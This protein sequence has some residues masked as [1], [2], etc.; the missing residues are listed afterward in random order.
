MQSEDILYAFEIQSHIVTRGGTQTRSSVFRTA[1]SIQPWE[2]SI[3]R[4]PWTRAS[5]RTGTLADLPF[6]CFSRSRRFDGRGLFE[7]RR[8]NLIRMN[9]PALNLAPRRLRGSF[10]FPF[11]AFFLSVCF[12]LTIQN[13][14]LLKC[15]SFDECFPRMNRYYIIL[16]GFR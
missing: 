12:S 4:L 1:L 11:S 7:G 3:S 9:P 13:K 14:I 16:L 15:E 8:S 10:V 5:R 2:D 6:F